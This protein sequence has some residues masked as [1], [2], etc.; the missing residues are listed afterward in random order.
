M[1]L[2]LLV[3]LAPALYGLIGLGCLRL[4]GGVRERFALA[5]LLGFCLAG[6]VPLVGVALGGVPFLTG[7]VLLLLGFIGLATLVTVDDLRRPECLRS[8]GL[9]LLCY[10]IGVLVFLVTPLPAFGLWGTDWRMYLRAG[11]A[12]LEFA[13][14]PAALGSLEQLIETRPRL[15]ASRPQLFSTAVAPLA[16]WAPPLVARELAAASVSASVVPALV[17]GARRLGRPEPSVLW[18]LF[19]VSTPLYTL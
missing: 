8:M 2:A 5:P 10:A 16:A 13:S 4:W 18:V 7:G 19:F 9:Y 14:D 15:F 17:Y 12:L 11:E 3:L 1:T 6:L